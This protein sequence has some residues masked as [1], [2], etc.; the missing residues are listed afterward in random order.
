MDE[1][2]N[3]KKF[4]SRKADVNRHIK[5]QHDVQWIDCPRKN[6]ERKGPRGFS[7]RDHLTEHLRGFHM[8]NIAKRNITKRSGKDDASPERLPR[9]SEI[10]D[11]DLTGALTVKPDR[12]LKR[13]S[14]KKEVGT[15]FAQDEVDGANLKRIRTNEIDQKNSRPSIT[16]Y[17]ASSHTQQ[18]PA[19]VDTN[20][21][22][23]QPM[24]L[25]PEI[26]HQPMMPHSIQ[27]APRQPVVGA[28]YAAAHSIS[29]PYYAPGHDMGSYYHTSSTPQQYHITQAPYHQTYHPMDPNQPYR[30]NMGN[31][32]R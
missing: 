12:K 22:V 20:R 11:A 32:Q 3:P 31:Q 9:S 2:G 15:D 29:S 10:D 1:E 24:V 25:S 18:R 13:G 5:S 8:E 19:N 14:P 7:R 27:Y 17:K 4:F 23:S 26:N 6:C 28:H 16:S 21:L 30:P